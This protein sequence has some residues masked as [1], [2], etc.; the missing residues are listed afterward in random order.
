MY[1]LDGVVIGRI[2]EEGEQVVVE[3]EAYQSVLRS[4]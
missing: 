2:A 1:T 4:P 3:M